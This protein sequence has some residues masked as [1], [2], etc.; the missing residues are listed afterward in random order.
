MKRL[1]NLGREQKIGRTTLIDYCRRLGY[2]NM[3]MHS[4]IDEVL[5]R[6]IIALHHGEDVPLIE[7]DKNSTEVAFSDDI[8]QGFMESNPFK[9]DQLELVL[10]HNRFEDREM[11]TV[12]NEIVNQQTI[13]TDFEAF[14]IC[15]GLDDGGVKKMARAFFKGTELEL[16]SVIEA[17]KMAMTALEIHGPRLLSFA[18]TLPPLP[19][20]AVD[21]VQ[22]F[23]ELDKRRNKQE[24]PILRIAYK[25]VKN[26]TE[27][28][29]I[30][31]FAVKSNST[32][33]RN[34][35]II[36]VKNK[37]TKQTLLYV[38]RSGTILPSANAKE[39]LPMLELFVRFSMNA[40][41]M[42][43]N[44]GLETGECSICGRELTDAESIKRGVGPICM[45]DIV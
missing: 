45:L 12:G 4:N 24:F 34:N 30:S 40:K 9:N 44:Y 6:K 39:I 32:R 29:Q 17:H 37:S 11:H 23:S 20:K 33:K 13:F 41:Q 38:T 42:I 2:S 16:D 43:L 3:T 7:W 31:Y 10:E 8:P 22:V 26:Q 35:D 21:P 25:N 15:M 14:S 27:K 36:V 5:E 28:I 1:I 19:F 18:L